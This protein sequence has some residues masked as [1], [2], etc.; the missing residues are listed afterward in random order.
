MLRNNP[1][2]CGR[3]LNVLP[4]LKM[5]NNFNISLKKAEMKLIYRII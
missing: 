4:Q 2:V 5:V 1:E 3:N